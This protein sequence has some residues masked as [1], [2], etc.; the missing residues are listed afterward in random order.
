MK[1]PDHRDLACPQFVSFPDQPG[2]F[3]QSHLFQIK[4]ELVAIEPNG[5]LLAHR[6]EI[7]EQACGRLIASENPF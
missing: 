2:I 1:E 5:S 4:T 7:A 3:H 6:V